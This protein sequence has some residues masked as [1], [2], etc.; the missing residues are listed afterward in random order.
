MEAYQVKN[1]QTI[2]S[3]EDISRLLIAQAEISF[4][5][6]WGEGCEVG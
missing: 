1:I 2:R 5:A 6:G 3:T 4:K